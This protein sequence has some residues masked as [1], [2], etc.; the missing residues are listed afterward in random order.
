MLSRRAKLPVARYCNEAGFLNVRR[1]QRCR[2][3]HTRH[4]ALE[5]GFTRQ[6][7]FQFLGVELPEREPKPF[8]YGDAVE[9]E[10]HRAEEG[11]HELLDKFRIE[12]TKRI[13]E[14]D[15]IMLRNE[16]S[17]CEE[18]SKGAAD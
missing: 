16:G 18:I 10:V 5:R 11:H 13:Q 3:S 4:P 12:L 7:A 1:E 2:A 17:Y 6:H 9:Q 14:W 8:V 15:T